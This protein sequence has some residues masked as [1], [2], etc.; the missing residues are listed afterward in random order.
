MQR[1]QCFCFF[2]DLSSNAGL[3]NDRS[4]PMPRA[5]KI[6]CLFDQ[7]INPGIGLAKGDISNSC[8]LWMAEAAETCNIEFCQA[9]QDLK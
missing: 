9:D 2:S 7:G 6:F 4:R 8:R 1:S 5:K 3:V